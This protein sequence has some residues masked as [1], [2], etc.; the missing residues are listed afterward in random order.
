MCIVLFASYCGVSSGLHPRSRLVQL[1]RRRGGLVRLK[2]VVVA[3][4]A[5]EGGRLLLLSL[6]GHHRAGGGRRLE[7]GAR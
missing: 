6:R 4:H 5:S 2:H 3:D 1:E 7:G